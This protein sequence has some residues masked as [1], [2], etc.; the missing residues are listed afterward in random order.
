MSDATI[1]AGKTE[2]RTQAKADAAAHAKANGAKKPGTIAAYKELHGQASA[3][4]LERVREQNHV[5]AAVRRALAEGPMT[6]P[7]VARAT[8]LTPRE[9]LWMLIAL[10]KYGVVEEDGQDGD[11][12]R[13]A[14]SGKDPRS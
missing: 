8:E 13:Y 7:E 11:Y 14:L 4:L 3:E 2:A 9:A 10:R 6:P 12:V 1:P 5:K